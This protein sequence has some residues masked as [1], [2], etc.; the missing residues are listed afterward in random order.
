VDNLPAIFLEAAHHASVIPLAAEATIYAMKSFGTTL[1]A[2]HIA[3]A[4]FGALAGQI[5]NFALGRWVMRLPS[6]PK[7]QKGF[8]ILQHYF[9]RFGFVALVFASASLGNILVVVSGMLG[10]PVKKALPMILLS[11]LYYY[12]RL[13]A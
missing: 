1:T 4:I 8:I 12:G 13:M 10:T 11:Y 6:S 3:T 9:N 7:N 5:F 2:M